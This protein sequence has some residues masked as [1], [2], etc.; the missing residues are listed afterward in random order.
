M[1]IHVY[2]SRTCVASY[3]GDE[4][5]LHQ[6]GE[7]AQDLYPGSTLVI[8]DED[9]LSPEQIELLDEIADYQLALALK[10]LNYAA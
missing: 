1:T 10:Q 9:E 3:Q 5:Q 8:S 4:N 7:I 2:H 6:I